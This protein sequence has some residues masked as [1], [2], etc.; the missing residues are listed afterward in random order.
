MTAAALY[1][2]PSPTVT[3]RILVACYDPTVIVG[4]GLSGET[5][6]QLH[7]DR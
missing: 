4:D 7:L 2:G 6:R 5:H 3:R 1:Q